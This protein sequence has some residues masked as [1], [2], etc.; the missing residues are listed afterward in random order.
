MASLNELAIEP[1][2]DNGY[3]ISGKVIDGVVELA[4]FTGDQALRFPDALWTL[5][6]EQQHQIV[7]L[8]AMRILLIK[9]GIY[10]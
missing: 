2:Q 9:A 4:D 6:P 5:E 3:T 1:T 7:R 8:I 10:E